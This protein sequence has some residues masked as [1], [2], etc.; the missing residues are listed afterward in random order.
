MIPLS[1]VRTISDFIRWSLNNP[2]NE[3]AGSYLDSYY[4]NYRLD[5]DRLDYVWR[6]TNERAA[7]LTDAA[8][9]GARI[10]DVGCGSGTNILWAAIHG[11]RA[12]G[13]DT[14]RTGIAVAEARRN[15]LESALGRRLDCQ[16]VA[17]N[18]LHFEDADGFDVVHLQEA[19][20]H[21]E[22]RAAV[23]EKLASLVRPGGVLLAQE[24]NA[25]N[26][27][28]QFQLF[29]FRGTQTIIVK[30]DPKT[31]KVLHH[32]GNERVLMAR[33]LT[34]LFAPK[35]FTADVRYFRLLPTR[36]A[37]NRRLARA[38]LAIEQAFGGM[39]ILKPFHVFYEWVGRKA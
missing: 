12:I 26:P 20:H 27:L 39:T 10:L 18:I 11:A 19:F 37:R 4:R 2:A 8:R 16:F 29:R 30:T 5:P 36:L 21:L 9:S 38:A 24:T 1:E 33:S 23:V 15:Q 35:G 3:K 31:G 22:P 7:R 6:F 17:T 34:R 28:L 32:Y 14:D 25:L 13:L